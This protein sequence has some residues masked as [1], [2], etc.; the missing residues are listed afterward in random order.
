[1][2]SNNDQ[3]N[4]NDTSTATPFGHQDCA[5]MKD[6]NEEMERL[7]RAKEYATTKHAPLVEE[8]LTTDLEVEHLRRDNDRLR[9]D[10]GLFHKKFKLGNGG[11]EV[12]TAIKDLPYI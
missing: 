7:K 10:N 2:T 3:D 6:L 4:G 12:L 9:L 11:R 8:Q 1:M 5:S